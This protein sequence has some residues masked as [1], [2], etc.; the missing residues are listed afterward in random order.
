MFETTGQLLPPCL[1]GF[2]PGTLTVSKDVHVGLI[3]D[4]KIT[5]GVNMSM[6]GY[7]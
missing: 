1:H 6:I 7:L 3:A 5:V 4:S 2:S